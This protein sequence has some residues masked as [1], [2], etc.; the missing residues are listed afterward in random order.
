MC[1]SSNS[2]CL[3][4]FSHVFLTYIS[5][6]V[7]CFIFF[8]CHFVSHFC[9]F[10]TD[11]WLEMGISLKVYRLAF[12]ASF[13]QFVVLVFSIT[14]STSYISPVSVSN[15]CECS[16]ILFRFIFILFTQYLFSLP[17]QNFTGCCLNIFFYELRP[18]IYLFI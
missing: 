16:A 12:V 7:W 14:I 5:T 3:L 2:I 11:A 6:Y 10:P 9:N 18:F 4:V 15:L 17:T 1:I 8:C 13:F